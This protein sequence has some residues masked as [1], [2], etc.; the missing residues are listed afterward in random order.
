MNSKL[1]DRLKHIWSSYKELNVKLQKINS[2]ES[3]SIAS[4]PS[5]NDTGREE[6]NS[7]QNL[8]QRLQQQKVG[9]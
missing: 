8:T 9:I 7:T 2:F 3:F 6:H 4:A 5:D 1:M